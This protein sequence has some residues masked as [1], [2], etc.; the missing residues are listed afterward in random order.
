[1]FCW[2]SFVTFEYVYCPGESFCVPVVVVGGVVY[3]GG[4]V[5]LVLVLVG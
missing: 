3:V 2:Y 5:A 4:S 1:M